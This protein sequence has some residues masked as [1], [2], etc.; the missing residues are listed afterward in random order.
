MMMKATAITLITMILL[1]ATLPAGAASTKEEIKA[2]S[3]QIEAMQKDLTE[4]KDMLKAGAGAGAAQPSGVA[5]FKEQTISVG[6][7]PYKGAKDATVTLIEY[8]DY[9]CPY[10][11][12]NYREVMPALVEEYVDTGKLKFVMRENPIPSLHRNAM[13]ASLAALCAGDQGKYW[14][15]HDIMFDNQKTLDVANLRDFAEKIGTNLEEFNE[16]LDSKKYEKRV[17]EDIKSGSNM[18]VSGTPAFVLGLTDPNDPDKAILSVYIRGAQPLASFKQA[19][20][21]LLEEAE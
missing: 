19:I 5:A 15:M 14:E 11:A 13:S 17:A 10:C 7:S 20:D 12:R 16:C 21:G 6:D 4:I 8:S 3:E 2:L 9:Q 1:A 18:G